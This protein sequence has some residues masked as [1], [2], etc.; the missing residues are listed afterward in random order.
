MENRQEMEIIL[1]TVCPGNELI[2]DE[3]GISSVMVKIPKQTCA[4]LGLG[5]SAETHPAFIINGKEVDAIYV[6][7]YENVIKDGL[8]YS[9][10]DGKPAVSVDFDE[11]SH[12]CTE[13]GL[14]WHLMSKIEWAL[15]AQWCLNNGFL[16]HGNCDFGKDICE[17]SY[18]G[19]PI[20]MKDG[21]MNCVL[22][23]TGPLEWSHDRSPSGIWDLKGNLGEWVAG[24]RTVFGEL[25]VL[26][27]NDAADG[28]NS[29]QADSG[30]WMAIDGVTGEYIKPDGKGTTPGSL[31]LEYM[32]S[33]WN[34]V[35]SENIARTDKFY[36]CEY[37]KIICSDEVS[38]QARQRLQVLGFYRLEE[39]DI[40]YEEDF[41][42]AHS[43][44]EEK[45]FG[46]G[47]HFK[48]GREAGVF[49]AHGTT[50]RSDT[51][52]TRGFRSAYIA[53]K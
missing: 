3:R 49:C 41:F 15:L 34:Y 27:D 26:R 28:R 2:T 45:I 25:Q 43:G 50:A 35:I 23:G 18:K 36:G 20:E 4:Q 38:A 19:I 44:A 31:K 21:K 13:K 1:H 47:G 5:D 9:V 12:A 24:A 6:S 52:L 42:Y 8:A 29:Q 48:H 10:P 16:P 32:D 53:F 46:C 14:G 7:K 37:K 33:V 11:A 39:K 30:A 22:T 51:S 17:K 40:T